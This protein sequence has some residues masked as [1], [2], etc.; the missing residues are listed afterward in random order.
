MI[1]RLCGL[2]LSAGL[3]FWV[4]GLWW[5][6]CWFALWVY[7]VVGCID[8]NGGFDIYV[9]VVA[10][11]CDC[12]GRGLGVGWLVAWFWVALVLVDVVFVRD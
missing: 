8:V 11:G 3:R 1:L 9:D 2:G 6:G 10:I 4:L 5:F 7:F 12:P